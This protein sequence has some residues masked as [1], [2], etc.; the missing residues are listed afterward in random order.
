M[1]TISKLTI[2]GVLSLGLFITQ[3][4]VKDDDYATPPIECADKLTANITIG[5]LTSKVTSGTIQ[6]DSNGAIAEDL[7]IDAYVISS[8][9]TGNFYKT[10]S[11]QDKPKEATAGIQIEIDGTNLYNEYPLG[12]RIQVSLKGLVVA[13]D[14]GIMK[15]GSVDPSFAVGRIPSAVMKKYIFKTCDEKQTIEPKVVNNLTE[16][17]KAENLN[18][19]VTINNIQFKEPEVDKTYGVQGATVNRVLIDKSGKTVD[20]RNSGFAKW[21]NEVL[22]TKSG[23][24]TVVVSI[25]NSSYQVYIRDTNDVKFDQ[26]RFEIGGG[27]NPGG[28]GEPSSNAIYLFEGADFENW[29]TFL[30]NITA[31]GIKP[32]ATQG[33]GN[34]FNN[35]NS[36]QIKGTPT[37]NDYVV[38]AKAGASIPKDPQAIYFKLK[39]TSTGK[40]LSINVNATEDVTTGAGPQKYYVFNL[41]D[42]KDT[43]VILDYVQGNDYRGSIDTKGKWINVKLNIKGLPKLDLQNLVNGF[44]SIKVGR[45][46]VYDIQIDDIK[47]D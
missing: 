7:I 36:L 39:G 23:S 47:I 21:Y 2:A 38:T 28:D 42:V 41:L 44:L 45:D 13:K 32:Y 46:G 30:D 11:L 9:E 15:I 4:C 37:G 12:A 25:F 40:T 14:R 26:D 31:N 24:I 10:I 3:S 27:E 5:E 29:Q 33:I 8:D 1:N 17:L 35:T 34:G 20:L 43:D 16:A 6:L 19:L 22:P 18:T